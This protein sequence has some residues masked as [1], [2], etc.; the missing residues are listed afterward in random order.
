MPA[1]IMLML[2]IGPALPIIGW[3]ALWL[4]NA[5]VAAGC[6]IVSARHA[7]VIAETVRETAGRFFVEA[8]NVVRQPRCLQ[9]VSTGVNR[10][11]HGSSEVRV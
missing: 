4:A 8:A 3:R 5:V 1:G 9:H 10:D 2:F 11:S 7:P 6:A